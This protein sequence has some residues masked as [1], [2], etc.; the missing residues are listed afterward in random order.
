MNGMS[1]IPRRGLEVGGLLVGTWESPAPVASGTPLTACASITQ[2]FPV[3]I[4]HEAGPRFQLNEGD[5]SAL[6]TLIDELQKAGEHVLGWWRSHIV[7]ENLALATEDLAL[8]NR[9]FGAKTVL[10]L[11][12]LPRIGDVATATLHAVVA[13]EYRSSLAFP[14]VVSSASAALPSYADARAEQTPDAF[15]GPAT[16]PVLTPALS[17]G[18]APA[19]EQNVASMTSNPKADNQPAALVKSSAPHIPSPEPVDDTPPHEWAGPAGDRAQSRPRFAPRFPAWDLLSARFREQ[20]SMRLGRYQFLAAGIAGA[21][22]V[23]LLL[24]LVTGGWS[25]GKKVRNQQSGLSSTPSGDSVGKPS[26]TDGGVAGIGQPETSASLGLK[27]RQANGAMHLEWDRT[28]PLVQEASGG[29]LLIEDGDLRKEIVLTPA[30]LRAGSVIWFPRTDSVRAQLTVR[31]DPESLQASLQVHGISA[32]VQP[33]QLTAME[34]N[35]PRR[36]VDAQGRPAQVLGS[37]SHPATPPRPSAMDTSRRTDARPARSA[38]GDRPEAP[39][40]TAGWPTP[41]DPSAVT[42]RPSPVEDPAAAM[43]TTLT[44]SAVSDRP[45][46]NATLATISYKERRSAFAVLRKLPFVPGKDNAS[47]GIFRAARTISAACPDLTNT[48]LSGEPEWVDI[49][50]EIDKRGVVQQAKL[51][52]SSAPNEVVAKTLQSV[53]AWRFDPATVSEKPVETEVRLRVVWRYPAS[54]ATALANTQ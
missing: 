19:V 17:P 43:R 31:G 32:S 11:L 52:D 48:R 33:R 46:C 27:A 16:L 20:A 35:E 54:S 40:Q 29:L 44:E 21:M 8:T 51:A 1:A 9:V 37:S 36:A 2:C 45:K 47:K 50:A 26:I 14:L 34:S 7:D 10:V 13:N 30:D 6:R 42:G 4:A 39:S 28:H 25:I 49:V 12:V 38:P 15:A 53:Q 18:A 5:E 22:G 23:A 3:E 41:E 24:F